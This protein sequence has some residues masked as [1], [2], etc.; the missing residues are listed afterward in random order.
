VP[1]PHGSRVVPWLWE[2][3]PTD[4]RYHL[5]HQHALEELDNLELDAETR[6]LFLAGNARRVLGLRE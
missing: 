1:T 3:A 5:L 6:D 2:A 4:R